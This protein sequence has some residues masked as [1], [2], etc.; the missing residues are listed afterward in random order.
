M[1]EY[2]RKYS[3]FSLCGLNCGLCPQYNTEGASKCPGCGGKDFHLKH[4]SCSVISCSSKN[5][6][7]EY[8]PDCISYPCKRYENI[9]T[10]D[11]FITYRNVK[12]DF[13]K[14]KRDG[15]EVYSKELGEKIRI[16]EFLI[17]NYNDGRRKSF[18]C[19]AVNLMELTDLKEIIHEIENNISKTDD[20]EKDKIKSI[21]SLF[22]DKAKEKNIE[23]RLR[24]K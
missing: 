7:V 12:K 24:N 15:I 4:P 17:E 13:E 5:G 16:L 6:N 10:K 23:L 18:Y 11:S 20:A 22:E 19:T 9:G 14:L 1:K 21:V 3:L 2:K 8:C